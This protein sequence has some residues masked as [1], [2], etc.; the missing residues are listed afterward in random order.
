VGCCH[1]DKKV[2]ER[3][4]NVFDWDAWWEGRVSVL[5]RA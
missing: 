3:L 5:G 1:V 2:R 4:A